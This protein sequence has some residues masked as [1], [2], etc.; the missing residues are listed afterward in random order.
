MRTNRS[1]WLIPAG[2]IALSA[3]PAVMGTLRLGELAGGRAHGENA[4]FHA[5]PLPVVLHVL[6]ASFSVWARCSSPPPSGHADAVADRRRILVPSA[7]WWPP[8][9]S[10]SGAVAP[11]PAGDGLAVYL[12]RVVSA[13][14]CSC[15]SRSAL[16]AIR[17]RD[18]ASTARDDAAYAIGLGAGT[19]VLTHLPWFVLADGGR[20]RCQRALMMSLLGSNVPRRELGD[21]RDA[22]AAPPQPVGS[23][24]RR[25]GDVPRDARV[26]RRPTP[27][28]T[29][30]DARR[31]HLAAIAA[32]LVGAFAGIALVVV[33]A[34][35]YWRRV[36]RRAPSPRSASSASRGWSGDRRH[37]V[38]FERIAKEPRSHAAPSRG[39]RAVARGR[40]ARRAARTV[41]RRDARA[42]RAGSR[43]AARRRAGVRRR[44]RAPLWRACPTAQPSSLRR[45]W[46]GV[47][48]MLARS[49]CFGEAPPARDRLVHAPCAPVRPGR[50]RQSWPLLPADRRR[51]SPR[52]GW[53]TRAAA[54]RARPATPGSGTA[55]SDT[56]RDAPWPSRSIGEGRPGARRS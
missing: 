41:A 38:E 17:R 52:A 12:E 34:H 27:P 42:S 19:Q 33:R 20:A 44:A 23:R 49:I 15:P 29:A 6:A 56:T 30:H 16:D 51:E 43:G 32:S 55:R 50:P 1:N 21:P 22:G 3:V 13:G 40:T 54:R 14:R 46:L 10:W 7:G 4:R 8:S 2:L 25:L 36:G 53:R 26:R 9:R 11:W 37:R 28:S 39:G 48:S 24:A 35:G 47:P 5:A 45:C 18:F 31:R